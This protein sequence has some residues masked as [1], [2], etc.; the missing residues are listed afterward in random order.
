MYNCLH[1]KMINI[2]LCIT[3]KWLSE[4]RV[5]QECQKI[6]YINPQSVIKKHEINQ[7]EMAY[8]L[9]KVSIYMIH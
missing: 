6:P 7:F 5:S 4:M 2:L 3:E 1:N 9:Y 8:F